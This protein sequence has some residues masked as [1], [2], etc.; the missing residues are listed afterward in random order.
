MLLLCRCGILPPARQLFRNV[1][2]TGLVK[3][4]NPCAEE[5]H[6]ALENWTGGRVLPATFCL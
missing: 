4:L 5:R 2:I 6:V 1:A 3:G